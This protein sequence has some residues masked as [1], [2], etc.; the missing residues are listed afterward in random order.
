MDRHV[1]VAAR[2]VATPANNPGIDD[3]LVERVTAPQPTGAWVIANI[4][5]GPP[6]LKKMNIENG[7]CLSTILMLPT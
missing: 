1:R 4:R 5:G 6:H 2:R 7:R 3:I